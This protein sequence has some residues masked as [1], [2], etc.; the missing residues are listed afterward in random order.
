[1]GRPT[2]PKGVVG[3]RE[4]LIAKLAESL[5]DRIRVFDYAA[6]RTPEDGAY[7]VDPENPWGELGTFIRVEGRWKAALDEW[8][9]VA[10]LSRAEAKALVK[11]APNYNIDVVLPYSTTGNP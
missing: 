5:P 10:G 8:A 4:A 1:M 3:V 7:G 6:W 11:C 2:S 9:A